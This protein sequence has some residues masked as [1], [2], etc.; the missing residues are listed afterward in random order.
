V[1]FLPKP[2]DSGRLLDE[3]DRCLAVKV[4]VLSHGDGAL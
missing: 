3:L 1:R 2:L 4:P